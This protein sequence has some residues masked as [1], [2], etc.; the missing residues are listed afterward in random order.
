MISQPF[1]IQV[2]Q[3]EEKIK[4]K[5]HCCP[6]INYQVAFC[7]AKSFSTDQLCFLPDLPNFH[8]SMRIFQHELSSQKFLPCTPNVSHCQK[9]PMRFIATT[10]K[11]LPKKLTYFKQK[12][13][14]MKRNCEKSVVI[15]RSKFSA[16]LRRKKNIAVTKF[17][18]IKTF[19]W[20]SSETEKG[21]TSW[22]CLV[23]LIS[24]PRDLYM[25]TKRIHKT[26]S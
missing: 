23:Q 16:I 7:F 20:D 18:R 21:L 4:M 6:T 15:L 9:V 25:C 11:W 26:F 3:L 22:D 10:K 14:L 5:L 17:I 13:L 12:P 2:N 24:K 1:H 8:I 19:R